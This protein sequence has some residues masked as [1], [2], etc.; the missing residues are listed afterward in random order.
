MLD[1]TEDMEVLLHSV[2][3]V[4]DLVK[5]HKIVQSLHT[6]CIFYALERLGQLSY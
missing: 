1:E 2:E 6:T 3:E 5:Q 4:K